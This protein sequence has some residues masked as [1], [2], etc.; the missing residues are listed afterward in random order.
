MR[1]LVTGHNGY[2]GSV[3]VPVLRVAGHDVQGLDT[4]FFEDCTVGLDGAYVPSL[5][6]D[7][8]DVEAADLDGVDAVIHL[9][10]LCDDPLGDVSP[11]RTYAINHHGA[12]RLA[13]SARDAGVGRFF[14]ASSCSVYGPGDG[15]DP[16]TENAPLRPLTPYAIS[17]ARAEEDIARLATPDFSP[18]FMR[19][20]TAYG[21]SARL[22]ADILLNNLVCWAHATGRV[23]IG[24]DGALWRPLIHVQDIARAFAAGLA[25]PREA[26]HGQ[27]FNV[28]VTGENYQVSELAEIVRA[29]V[30]GCSV[31]HVA[32]HDADVR[33]FRLDFGKLART[34]P[35]FK[36]QWNAV[37]GAKDLY[38]ALQDAEV[39][40]EDL[41]GRKYVRL[42]QLK[43]LL[44]SELVD[45]QLRWVPTAMSGA[46][47]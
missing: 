44:S 30:P 40:V 13:R 31:E 28:G 41:Q 5:R 6:K 15:G 38:A 11:E 33:S 45:E 42:T 39:T 9:A 2:I 19:S 35:D 7:I 4:F 3:L 34:L 26:V 18:V 29:A 20:A 47:G 12:V 21:V 36:P 24:S 14:L 37:F 27:A 23:R 43:Y 46:R 10:A 8:R 1:V 25:V 32:G 16:L 22:R 17:K